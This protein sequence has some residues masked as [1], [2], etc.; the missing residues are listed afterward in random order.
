MNVFNDLDINL[1][2]ITNYEHLCDV[3][4]MR[5]LPCVMP[6]LEGMQSLNKL[7]LNV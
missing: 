3:E 5:G 1:I 4:T 7:A 6:M 2:V